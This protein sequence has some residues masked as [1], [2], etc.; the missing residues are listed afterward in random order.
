MEITSVNNVY[1]E[2]GNLHVRIEGQ[3]K[4][5]K[6]DKNINANGQLTKLYSVNSNNETIGDKYCYAVESKDQYGNVSYK[7]LGFSNIT[8]YFGDL[9]NNDRYYNDIYDVEQGTPQRCFEIA[10]AIINN[11]FTIGCSIYK[12]I[13][14]DTLNGCSS[15]D[16]VFFNYDECIKL[17]ERLMRGYTQAVYKAYNSS[18]IYDNK[19]IFD[20]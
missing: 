3:L 17:N 8:R 1:L 11:C 10:Q 13:N 18:S 6:I 12:T 19:I 5:F 4:L 9:T 20:N 16:R 2:K 15:Y 7:I 14:N